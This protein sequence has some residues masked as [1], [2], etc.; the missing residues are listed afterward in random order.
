MVFKCWSRVLVATADITWSSRY[1]CFGEGRDE[2][3]EVDRFLVQANTKVYPK[4]RGLS[5]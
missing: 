1:G 3:R 2:L 4:V 5:R